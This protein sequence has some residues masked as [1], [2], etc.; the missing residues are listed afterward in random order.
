MWKRIGIVGL[1]G[2]GKT[3]LSKAI[4]ITDPSGTDDVKPYVSGDSLRPENL[5]K[6]CSVLDSYVVEHMSLSNI[7]LHN[8]GLNLDILIYLDIPWQVCE[9]RIRTRFGHN[10][11]LP[12]ELAVLEQEIRKEV[13]ELQTNGVCVLTLSLQDEKYICNKD[14]VGQELLE[15]LMRKAKA[16]EFVN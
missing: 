4:I 1:P 5:G 7:L 10:V 2:S 16:D 9:E 11:G 14:L 8:S 12:V 15:Y 13:A 6:V 3:L